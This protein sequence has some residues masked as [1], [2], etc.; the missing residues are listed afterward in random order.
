MYSN[1]CVTARAD[2][3]VG[4]EVVVGD[5]RTD[6]HPKG[7]LRTRVPVAVKHVGQDL[8]RD[9]IG[10]LDRH[11]HLLIELTRR[12]VLEGLVRVDEPTSPSQLGPTGT[13]LADDQHEPVDTVA[14]RDN[15]HVVARLASLSVLL[16]APVIGALRNIVLVGRLVKVGRRVKPKLPCFGNVT[17][18]VLLKLN[19]FWRELEE[20]QALFGEDGVDLVHQADVAE[21]R[22]HESQLKQLRQLHVLD[23]VA[24]VEKCEPHMQEGHRLLASGNVH[25]PHKADERSVIFRRKL[26]GLTIEVGNVELGASHCKIA[27]HF[28][29]CILLIIQFRKINFDIYHVSKNAKNIYNTS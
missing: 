23:V 16:A 28:S 10:A 9:M 20:D 1:R 13:V 26:D 15:H 22:E 3:L 5:G 17:V 29:G 21:A 11:V 7:E 27:L 18:K 25:H 14:V 4:W 2:S 24:V 8:L 6:L 12:A 19:H